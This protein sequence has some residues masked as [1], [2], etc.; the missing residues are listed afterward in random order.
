[1]ISETETS[2]AHN[3][4]PPP[5]T[6]QSF[7]SGGFESA[8]HINAQGERLDLIAGTR[9]DQMVRED[10]LLLRSAGISTARDGVRWHLIDKGGGQYD[11]SSFLPMLRA[12]R[13]TGTQVVWNFFHYG[14]PDGLDLLSPEFVD[15]FAA[16]ARALA[17]LIREEAGSPIYVSLVNEISFFSWAAS[18]DVIYP[19]AFGKDNEIKHQLIRAAIAGSEAV[20]DVEPSAR[21]IWGDPVVHVFPPS[22]VPQDSPPAKEAL[23]YN[24]AQYE[25]WDML[26]GRL[27]PEL[28]GAE[29]YLD[30]LG[31]NYYHANQ[32][33]HNYGR[34]R[35]EDEPRDPRW[36]PFET[37]LNDLWM[38]YRRP[39]W[40][41]ETS[42]FGDGR[43]RWI[44]EIGKSV[45]NARLM[46]VPVEGICLFPIIDRYD[47]TD[48]H[49]W[50]HSGLFDIDPAKAFQR[51]LN[52]PY[53]SALRQVQ[54]LLKTIG[55]T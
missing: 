51:T 55:C 30:I 20:L 54:D 6:F 8:C 21:L 36:R 4:A 18:R 34:L 7:W 32:W 50:H 53:A 13:E 3:P 19:F 17:K 47:W 52:A 10:Y 28:G 2:A 15:R 16:Y 41:A 35:W 26:A 22:G 38:R 24:E 48:A 27:R 9:H 1:M 33:E 5:C 40:I 14:W 23:R 39:I 49:H 11:F 12:A 37:M 46:G 44:L 43:G 42:H 29:K 25:A 31:A 45:F